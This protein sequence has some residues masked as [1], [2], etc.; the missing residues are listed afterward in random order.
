MSAT[1]AVKSTSTVRR[2]DALNVF[3]WQ[4]TDKR[5]QVMKGAQQAKIPSCRANIP[6]AGRALLRRS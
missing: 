2:P 4:G 6:R 5:G 3:V 1:R